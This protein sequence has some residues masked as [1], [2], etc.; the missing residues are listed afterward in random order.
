MKNN[1]VIEITTNN[2]RVGGASAD[3]TFKAFA[4]RRIV[5]AHTAGRKTLVIREK[6]QN[7]VAHIIGKRGG[8]MAQGKTPQLAFAHGVAKF[9]K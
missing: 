7:F 2:V 1:S 6:G 3:V 5:R 8:V 4:E 9:W